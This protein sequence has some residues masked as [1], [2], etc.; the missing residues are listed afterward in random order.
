MALALQYLSHINI[1]CQKRYCT[2]P[3]FSQSVLLYNWPTSVHRKSTSSLHFLVIA[4]VCPISTLQLF[5][6]PFYALFSR[7][8][9]FDNLHALDI[10]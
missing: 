5:N 1:E 2:K 9:T 3:L 8:G 4:Y 10:I 6:G 7:L